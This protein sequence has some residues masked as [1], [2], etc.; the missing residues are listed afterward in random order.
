[1]K[2]TQKIKHVSH[3]ASYVQ[4]CNYNVHTLQTT[5]WLALRG[6]PHNWVISTFLYSSPQNTNLNKMNKSQTS[7][8]QEMWHY[9]Y[10]NYVELRCTGERWTTLSCLCAAAEQHL[11][12]VCLPTSEKSNRHICT[13]RK[14]NRRK[15]HVPRSTWIVTHILVRRT[16]SLLAFT[17]L[18]WS[19]GWKT[20]S[21]L[22]QHLICWQFFQTL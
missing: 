18:I 13:D 10:W 6:A 15:I 3:K 5:F 1:M 22:S 21:D 17:I 20:R 12:S 11:C 14:R 19:S 2:N 16:E 8:Q 7:E 4:S 9:V